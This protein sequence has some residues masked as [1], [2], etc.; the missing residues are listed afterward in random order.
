[1]LLPQTWVFEQDCLHL[2]ER[3]TPL[4][5]LPVGTQ[6]VPSGLVVNV[7][8]PLLQVPSLWQLSGAAHV[9]GL[10]RQWPEPSHWSRVQASPS[11]AQGV[12]AGRLLPVQVP[13]ASQLPEMQAPV[14][15][16]QAEP[17]G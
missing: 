6:G 2:P 8:W 14:E 17:T 1:M 9:I 12:P 15:L 11:S 3:Q 10:W 13:L 16:P 4:G 7:H 5:Q